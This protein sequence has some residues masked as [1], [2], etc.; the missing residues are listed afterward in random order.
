MG[1]LSTLAPCLVVTRL[2]E[3]VLRSELVRDDI[4]RLLQRAFGDVQRVGAHIGDEASGAETAEL[5]AL[6]ELLGKDHRPLQRVAELARRLLL[7]R[8]RRERRRRVA[9]ALALLEAR[10]T[11]ERV[12]QCREVAMRVGLAPD[13]QLLALLLNELGG[14]RLARNVSRKL[15]LPKRLSRG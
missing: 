5:D 8:R 1:L 9:A 10:D 11:E 6:V 14:E 2:V 3:R 12:R 4:V 15:P 13:V 7:E